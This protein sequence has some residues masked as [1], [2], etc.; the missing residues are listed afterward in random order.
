M[1]D[2][3][4]RLRRRAHEALQAVADEVAPGNDEEGVAMVI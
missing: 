4:A 3:D 2:V 1:A